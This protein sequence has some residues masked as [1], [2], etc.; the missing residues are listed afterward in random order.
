LGDVLARHFLAFSLRKC[1]LP[2]LLKPAKIVVV[3]PSS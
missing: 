3:H 2:Q 1:R